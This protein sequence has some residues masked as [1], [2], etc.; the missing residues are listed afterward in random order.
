MEGSPLGPA[1]HAL[2]HL[3]DLGHALDAGELGIDKVVELA[4]FAEFETEAGLIAWA[5]RVSCAAVR[6]KADLEVRRTLDDVREAER[7]LPQ[8]VASTTAAGW[9]SRASCPRRKARPW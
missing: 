2:E 3:T 1:P 9:D 6:R 4:R 7:A 5:T 8:L